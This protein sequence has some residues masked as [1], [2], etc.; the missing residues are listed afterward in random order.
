MENFITLDVNRLIFV[1]IEQG[2]GGYGIA[3]TLCS[4]DDVYWYNHPDNGITPWDIA[5][6]ETSNIRQRKI[7]PNH[8]DRWINGFK[9]PPT[10]DYLKDYNIDTNG[11]LNGIFLKGVEKALLMTSKRLVFTTHLTP[12]QLTD[13]FGSIACLNV[14]YDPLEASKR[15]I[16]TTS[17]FPAYVKFADIVPKDNEYLKWLESIHAIKPNFTIA[18]V[19]AMKNHNELYKEDKHLAQYEGELFDY[20]SKQLVIRKQWAGPSVYNIEGKV[21]WNDAKEFLGLSKVL[22]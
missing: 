5:S 19:W 20:M 21:N 6:A 14:L 2:T 17:K 9:I 1:S 15:Y 12:F 10:P 7:S 18:D 16:T 22:N 4:L 11:Y 3:R 8:F 13:Y